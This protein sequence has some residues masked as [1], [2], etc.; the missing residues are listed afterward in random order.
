MQ[1]IQSLYQQ[2]PS[3]LTMWCVSFLC[4]SYHRV[5]EGFQLPHPNQKKPEVLSSSQPT[6]QKCSSG[7]SCVH[8]SCVLLVLIFVQLPWNCWIMWGKSCTCLSHSAYSTG[9]SAGGNL[10]S[11][12]MLK[13]FVV[14]KMCHEFGTKTT[15]C[16]HSTITLDH[17]SLC[18]KGILNFRFFISYACTYIC[19]HLVHLVLGIQL[20]RSFFCLF[21]M[22][23][24]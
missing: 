21:A 14:L 7:T 2:T 18:N 19:V 12:S 23:F 16:T 20:D 10:V 4:P 22:L 15:S 1:I 9:F 11:Y 13:A 24:L 8:C 6:S 17:L 3:L 5:S